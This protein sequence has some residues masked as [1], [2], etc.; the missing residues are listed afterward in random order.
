MLKKSLIGAAIAGLLVLGGA[1]AA[2]ADSYPPDGATLTVS[3]ASIAVGGTATLTATG[4]GELETVYFGS[5]T[6]AGGT[7]ASIVSASSTGPVAKPVTDGTA[8]ATFTAAQPGTYTLAVSDGET[9]LD[10]ATITVTAAG[11]GAGGSG[12]TGGAGGNLPATGSEVP[13][14][15]LWLGV[16]AL[17]I[18]GIAVAAAVARRR[19]QNN[20]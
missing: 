9:V 18:G 8:T 13:A 16:G 12:G 15:A 10:T 4:L 14:A 17:G 3:P 19:A 6:P 11:S 1:S 20:H 5:D 2:T 7:I